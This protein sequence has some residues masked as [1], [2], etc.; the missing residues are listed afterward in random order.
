MHLIQASTQRLIDPH[1]SRYVCLYLLLYYYSPYTASHH[2]Y[3][4]FSTDHISTSTGKHSTWLTSF[5]H[6]LHV[7]TP[8]HTTKANTS[9]IASN[10]VS[11]F[12][13]ANAP[14]STSSDSLASVD[15]K[16]LDLFLSIHGDFYLLNP[17]ST[18]SW[19]VYVVRVCLGMLISL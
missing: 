12:P 2:S 4:C 8:S 14:P 15:K 11:P 17:L 3:Y 16:F 10:I 6:W 7:S 9:S 19:Q 13:S 5:L 18:F 1:I